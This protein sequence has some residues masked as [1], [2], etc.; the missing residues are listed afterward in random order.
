MAFAWKFLLPLAL[1]NIFVVAVDYYVPGIVGFVL[2]WVLM[3]TAVF[4]IWAINSRQTEHPYDTTVVP[5]PQV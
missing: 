3:L 4:L 5:V 2:A 1:I